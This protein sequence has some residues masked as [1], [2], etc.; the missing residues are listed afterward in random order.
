MGISKARNNGEKLPR[1]AAFVAAFLLYSCALI[2]HAQES[3]KGAPAVSDEVSIDEREVKR[4]TEIKK[5]YEQGLFKH[6]GVIGVGVGLSKDHQRVVIRVYLDEAA[7]K[8]SLPTKLNGVPVEIVKSKRFKA[9]DGPGGHR[10]TRPRPVPM[11]TSTGNSVIKTIGDDEV[12]FETVGTLGFRVRRLQEQTDPKVKPDPASAEVGYITANHV[13]AAAPLDPKDFFSPICPA[14]IGTHTLE[15]NVADPDMDPIFD[16]QD[17]LLGNLPESGVVQCQP[18]TGDTDFIC[19]GTGGLK[20]GTLDLVIPIVMGGEFLNTMD[21]AFVK[22][23]RACVSRHILD[24]GVPGSK[25]AFPQLGKKVQKSGRGSGLT[26]G[27]V[28]TVNATVIVDY[29]NFGAC[30]IAKFT[31][32]AIVEIETDGGDSGAPVLQGKNPVGLLLAGNGTEAAVTPLPFILS[33]LGV[34][35]DSNQKDGEGDAC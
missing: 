4:A 25:S 34:E 19:A 33:A 23:S 20:I 5:K 35:L 2:A 26:T 16:F 1:V 13:A 7:A 10:I 32:Q 21:A 15:V 17:F 6:R 12:A 11:G 28:T 30:G 29:S 31:N 22:S 9:L 3:P 18:G 27:I 24:I 8:P 14:S